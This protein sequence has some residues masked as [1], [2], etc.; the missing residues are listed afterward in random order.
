M[1]FGV[2]LGIAGAVVVHILI[3]L[4]G[5]IFFMHGE[6]GIDK[7][8]EVELLSETE[9]EKPKEQEKPQETKPSEEIE[10]EQEEIQLIRN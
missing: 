6:D 2:I 7:T 8:R 1:N 10:E 4:F 3:L 5:G 9:S